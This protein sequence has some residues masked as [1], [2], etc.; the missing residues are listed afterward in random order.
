MFI[1]D[2]SLLQTLKIGR[3][4]LILGVGGS[5]RP[6]DLAGVGEGARFGLRDSR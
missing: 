2:I 4:R 6:L 5:R 1:E 3:I